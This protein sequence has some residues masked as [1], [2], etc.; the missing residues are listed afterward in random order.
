MHGASRSMTAAAQKPKG[1]DKSKFKGGYRDHQK[2][3]GKGNC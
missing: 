3:K 2:G 1:K